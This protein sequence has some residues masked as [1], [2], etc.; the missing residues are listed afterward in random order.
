LPVEDPGDFGVGVVHGKPADQV[1]GVVIGADFR[2]RAAQRDGSLDCPAGPQPLMDFG[3][4]AGSW[5]RFAAS[6][7]I[8]C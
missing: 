5:A 3:E 1:N 7:W 4:R 8:T 2:L 6:A